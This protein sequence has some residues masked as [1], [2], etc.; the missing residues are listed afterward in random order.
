MC[1]G[2]F[3]FIAYAVGNAS[4]ANYLQLHHVPGAD[5]LT[6]FCGAMVGAGLGF[7]LLIPF[8]AIRAMGAGDVKFLAALGALLGPQTLLV[9]AAASGSAQVIVQASS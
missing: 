3:A 8:Y 7:L 1:T 4:F 9:A 6:V 2:C 5:E